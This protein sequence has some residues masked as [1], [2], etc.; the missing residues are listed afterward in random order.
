MMMCKEDDT[1]A[2]GNR[3]RR[4]NTCW[5]Q[6][7]ECMLKEV[8]TSSMN[9]HRPKHALLIDSYKLQRKKCYASGR[10]YSSSSVGFDLKS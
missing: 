8:Q 6:L 9:Y 1:W 4:M 5:D 10:V 7:L 3:E 2:L